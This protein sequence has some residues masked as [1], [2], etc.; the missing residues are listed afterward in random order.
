MPRAKRIRKIIFSLRGKF[1]TPFFFFYIS[2]WSVKISRVE[3]GLDL[4]FYSR[5]FP[6]HVGY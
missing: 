5:G 4:Q 6:H 3:E 1:S 2:F